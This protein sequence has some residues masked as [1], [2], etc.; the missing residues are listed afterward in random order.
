MSQR[1][2]IDVIFTEYVAAQRAGDY[3]PRPFLARTDGQDREVLTTMIDAYL[4]TAPG[5]EWDPEAF[6]GSPAEKL[7]APMTRAIGGVSGT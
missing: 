1:E 7:V 3:N 4:M 5:R 6:K 2:D